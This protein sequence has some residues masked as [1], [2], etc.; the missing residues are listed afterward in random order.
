[1]QNQIKAAA[2]PKIWLRVFEDMEPRIRRWAFIAAKMAEHQQTFKAIGTRHRLS[3]WYIG[4]AAQGRENMTPRIIHA[5]EKDL[6]IDLG[7][8]LSPDEVYKTKKAKGKT[9][10]EPI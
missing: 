4:A 1:M 6:R 8:F 9:N 2:D 7:P 5:L 10:E 3:S